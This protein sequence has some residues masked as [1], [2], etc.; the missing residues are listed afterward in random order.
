M[1]SRL[2]SNQLLIHQI[3]LFCKSLVGVIIY[4]CVLKIGC[5]Y[6][7]LISTSGFGEFSFARFSSPVTVFNP[8]P[9]NAIACK[10]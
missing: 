7:L 2:S 4:I 5:L 10:T 1:Y 9:N 8:C 6:V 3:N